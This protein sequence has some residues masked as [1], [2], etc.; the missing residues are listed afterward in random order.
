MKMIGY[1]TI[2]VLTCKQE[3][4]INILFLA[5]FWAFATISYMK[6]TVGLNGFLSKQMSIQYKTEKAFSIQ[7][8]V[9]DIECHNAT[10]Y[11]HPERVF[12]QKFQIFEFGQTFWAEFF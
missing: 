12:F 9:E 5:H 11:G 6:T 4:T 3:H 10:D 1:R 2:N 8:C 7:N